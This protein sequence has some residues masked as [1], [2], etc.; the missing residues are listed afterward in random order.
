MRLTYTD[1]K[2]DFL[3]SVGQTGSVDTN[4]INF[5]KRALSSR[6]QLMLAQLSNYQ[7]R[8]TKTATTVAAQ[9]Y[10]H[11]PVGVVQIE[12]MTVTVGSI[13]YPLLSV[14]SQMAWDRLNELL[15]STSAIPQFFFAKRDE[16]GIWPVPQGAYLITLNY[17]L[18]DRDLTTEDYTTG[19]VTVTNDSP[20]VTGSGTTF[21]SA[22]VG[23]WLQIRND[24]YWYRISGFVSS[25]E[26]T[27]ETAYEGGSGSS[28]NYRIGE[29]PELPE[30]GHKLLSIGCTADY[31]AGPKGD[32]QKATWFNN[33]FWT[34][35]GNNND[36]T[37]RNVQGGLMGLQQRYSS[38]SNSG[39]V[40]RKSATRLENDKLWATRIS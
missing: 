16:F 4:L 5:F 3:D 39:V 2:N 38:R 17:N 32:I 10:Y 18:R 11:N 35:D 7:T 25:T 13:A 23:R 8:I 33:V 30:E 14:D 29:T 37:G 6:Y 15:I 36:R 40:Y 9:Q 24:G 1:L 20:T 22:M 12:N 21:T 19:T 28:L 34:G 27:L 31:F 26:I